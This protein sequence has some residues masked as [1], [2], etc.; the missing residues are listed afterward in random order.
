MHESGPGSRL[1]P[2]PMLLTYHTETNDLTA[3]RTFSDAEHW[4]TPSPPTLHKAFPLGKLTRL[5]GH[6]APSFTPGCHTC[7]ECPPR[8]STPRRRSST[9]ASRCPKRSA[10]GS[11]SRRFRGPSGPRTQPKPR[12]SSPRGRLI[13]SLYTSRVRQLLRCSRPRCNMSGAALALEGG[14]CGLLRHLVRS[15]CRPQGRRSKGRD[16]VTSNAASLCLG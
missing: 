9:S 7:L 2:L 3:F 1:L 4:R 5:Q 14:P 15:R 12:F 16:T 11:V 13:D 6:M 8:G 10:R